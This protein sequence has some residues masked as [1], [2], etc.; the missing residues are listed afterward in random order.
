VPDDIKKVVQGKFVRYILT[1]SGKV[2]GMG[3]F[4]HYQ[5]LSNRGE[6]FDQFVDLTDVWDEIVGEHAS[7]EKIVDVYSGKH[8]VMIITEGGKLFSSG[9][10]SYRYYDD[11]I[12]QNRHN[13]EDYPIYIKPPVEG[14]KAR[15]VFHTSRAY[16]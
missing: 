7:G 8:C 14:M 6:N 10:V 16:A 15:C 1:N 11:E 5:A 2:F 13:H 9:Y 4:K 3:R 12:R